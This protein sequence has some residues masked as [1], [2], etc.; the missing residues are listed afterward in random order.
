MRKVR[1]VGA[2]SYLPDRVV[3]NER[4]TRAIP[5]WS[6]DRLSERTGIVERR[7]LWDFD[8]DTGRALPPPAGATPAGNADMAELALRRALDVAG[9]PASQ[10]DAIFMV[11]PT[12]D[13]LN[14]CHD[15]LVVHERMGCRGDCTALVVDSGCGGGLYMVDMAYRM[16]RTG[17]LRTVAVVASTLVSAMVDRAVF[18]C[19]L[20]DH[21]SDKRINGCLS[22]YMFGDGAGA[23]VL[24]GDEGSDSGIVASSA[25]TERAELVIRRGGGARLP[26]HPGRATLA[27]HAFYVDG[28]LVA[29]AYPLYMHRALGSL[30]EARPE[31]VPELERYYLHQAN[32]RVLLAFAEEARLP[33]DRVPLNVERYGNTSAASTLILFA[34][35]VATGR[36][37][38]GSGTPVLLAACGAGVHY[39]GQ[40]LRA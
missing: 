5:G 6:A 30:V 39:A 23:I 34:E 19:D 2:G 24:R 13:E 33:T 32:K 40:I 1:V 3:K 4:I 12:P 15:A 26:P 22:M 27:D 14:F 16:I 28:P 8:E 31:L 25:G 29:K 7:F 36:I 17:S 21:G 38:L 35:D 10:L 11:T 20:A 37:R 18:A 9:L